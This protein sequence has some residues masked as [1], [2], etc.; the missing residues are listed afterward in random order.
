M[1]TLR[2]PALMKM[3]IGNQSEV[4]LQGTTVAETLNDLIFRY[5]AIKFHLYDDHGELRRHINLFVNEV[6][7]KDLNGI[8]TPICDF[9]RLILLPSI[10]GG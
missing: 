6:N 2:V 7:I 3:Y 9:D 5:P 10:S 8:Q 1:A 4:T